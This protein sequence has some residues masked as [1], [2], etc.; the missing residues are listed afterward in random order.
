MQEAEDRR[1]AAEQQDPLIQMKEREVAAREAEVQ[2]KAMG[3]QARFQLAA[4]KQQAD[5]SIK[6][7]ELQLEKEKIESDTQIKG[8]KIGAK[9]ASE[10]L[11]NEKVSK[12]QAVEDF[13]TG[14][15]IAKDIVKDSN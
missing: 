5:Q 13:K 2:R 15:D 10:L 12:K 14:I 8:T 3:D 6:V 7:A 1:I 11:E 9:I 4:Q